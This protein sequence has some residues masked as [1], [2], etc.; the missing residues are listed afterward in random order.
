MIKCVW[1]CWLAVETFQC[2]VSTSEAKNL[3][4]DKLLKMEEDN[5]FNF[6]CLPN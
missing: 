1:V 2:L 5:H 4:R 6:I 3:S